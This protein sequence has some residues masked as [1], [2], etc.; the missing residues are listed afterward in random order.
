MSGSVETPITT[1][2]AGAPPSAPLS[3]GAEQAATAPAIATAAAAPRIR[4]V[5][6]E[7]HIQ[8]ARKWLLHI[9]CSKALPMTAAPHSP[10]PT[11]GTACVKCAGVRRDA[12]CRAP[13][14]RPL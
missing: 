2:S 1:E 5:V 14:A 13:F 12:S 4:R 11:G 7:P 3:P 8:V 6:I 9:S 10:A